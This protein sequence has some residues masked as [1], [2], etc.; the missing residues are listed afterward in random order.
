MSLIRS[1]SQALRV[2]LCRASLVG[3]ARA[4]RSAKRGHGV[5]S[6]T[7][8]EAI[9][10]PNDMIEPVIELDQA[11]QRLACIDQRRSRISSSAT[12]GDCRSRR[13][14]GRWMFR[15]QPSNASCERRAPGWPPSWDPPRREPQSGAAAPEPADQSRP[16]ILASSATSSSSMATRTGMGVHI[17]DCGSP[18]GIQRAW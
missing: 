16:S 11:L 7:L 4:R 10:M 13:S 6:I 8:D 3:H 17:G 18:P 9:W 2:R 12:S 1:G 14:R 5:P 15:W